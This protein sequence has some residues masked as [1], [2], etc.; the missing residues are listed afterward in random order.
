MTDLALAEPTKKF[1]VEMLTRDVSLQ[2]AILDLVDNAVDSFRQSS[3]ELSSGTIEINFN[4]DS[5]QISDNA[6]GITYSDA[7]NYVFSFGRKDDQET[8]KHGIGLYGVGLKRAVFKIGSLITVASRSRTS[9]FIVAID[10]KKW[11]KLKEWVFPFTVSEPVVDET[12]DTFT[13]VEIKGIHASIS[14]DFSDLAFQ[15]SLLKSISS[16]HSLLIINGLRI[17]VNGQIAESQLPKMLMSDS[18][19]PHVSNLKTDG[20]EVLIRAGLMTSGPDD[21]GW[22]VFCNDRMILRA[23]KTSLT[24]W[25]MKEGQRT[26]QYHNQFSKFRGFV[27]INSDDGL[28]LP[29]NTTK[30]SL[31][32][33]N[34]LYKS[35]VLPE[36]VL[37]M[38]KLID[39]LNELDREK[40]A[41]LQ[42]F[43]PGPLS[44]SL[45]EAKVTSQIVELKEQVFEIRRR[46][47][48]AEELQTA[49]QFRRPK[50][51]VNRVIEHMGVVSA[52]A[53]GEHLFDT[54]VE[55]YELK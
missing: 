35:V 46:S 7:K 19:L 44:V 6:N 41:E 24:G 16:Y 55:E 45:S 2:S 11:L 30:S 52:V 42:G 5:F 28:K 54:Y 22:T 27:Y 8:Q 51:L 12:K 20:V 21:A 14:S 29:W 43:A 15:A 23:D 53:V 17:F 1:F 39:I 3:R 4:K 31:D 32:P 38:R 49:I 25:G 47:M 13:K 10:V 36:M 34:S 50:A 37:T 33:E 9:N 40:E 48:K 18:V 26:P